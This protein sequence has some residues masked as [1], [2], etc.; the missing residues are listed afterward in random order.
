MGAYSSWPIFAL[1]HGL[2]VSYLSKK[3]GKGRLSFKILGDDIVIRS[4]DL[5]NLYQET[6]LD[7]GVPISK[8]KTMSSNSTFEFAKR[9]FHNGQ[10]ISPFPLSAIHELLT[11]PPGVL[12][13]FRTAAEKGWES[14]RDCL[15]TV[16]YKHWL[17]QHNVNR[18]FA[19]K[20]VFEYSLCASFPS[21][22]DT[23][24]QRSEKV[25]NL[26]RL[27]GMDVSCVS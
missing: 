16:Q 9:W 17:S 2:L 8:S 4:D 7:L 12:E 6:L 1:T 5:N 26:L 11:T 20:L 23:P 18:A 13:T 3:L 24:Y 25:V 14:S 21:S 22:S 27:C 19:R 10:E 15:G